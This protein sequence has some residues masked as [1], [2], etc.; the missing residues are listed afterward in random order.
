MKQ[1]MDKVK[2]EIKKGLSIGI[3]DEIQLCMEKI[4]KILKD[5]ES[6]TNT[7]PPNTTNPKPNSPSTTNP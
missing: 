7:N 3:Q 6:L 4:E 1:R 2:Q 5:R